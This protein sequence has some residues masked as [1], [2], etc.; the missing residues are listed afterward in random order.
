MALTLGFGAT[1][2]A[3]ALFPPTNLLYSFNED[4]LGN[5]YIEFTWTAPTQGGVPTAYNYT[6]IGSFSETGST[7][8][9]TQII[10]N[11]PPNT[12]WTMSV[13]SFLGGVI[14]SPIEVGDTTP[15]PY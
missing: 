7:S 4:G 11:V 6:F 1:A 2:T 12:N 13:A 15:G 8:G 14:S 10:Y 5:Y 3:E 9:T